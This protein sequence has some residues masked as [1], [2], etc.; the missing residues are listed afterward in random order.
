MKDNGTCC[1]K[2]LIRSDHKYF[3]QWM[4]VECNQLFDKA[5]NGQFIAS[6]LYERIDDREREKT[7]KLAIG[8]S[9]ILGHGNLFQSVSEV[10]KTNSTH[11][12]NN[13]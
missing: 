6:N 3:G 12:T 4:C 8:I 13:D 11:D 1:K 9:A 7:K 2:P 10:N 5:F